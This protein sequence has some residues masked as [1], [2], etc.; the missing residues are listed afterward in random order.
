MEEERVVIDVNG[1]FGPRL[2]PDPDA[3]LDELLAQAARYR[4]G[5]TLAYHTTAVHLDPASG[6]DAAIAAADVSDGAI[7]PVAVVASYR[8][9]L[10]E[11][12]VDD[13]IRRGVVGFRL[14]VDAREWH[15]GGYEAAYR[16]SSMRA[17]LRA[18]ARAGTPII[19]PPLGWGRATAIGE[20]T[21]G[22]GVPVLI[23]GSHYAGNADDLAALDR[24]PHLYLETSRLAHFRAIE[25]AVRLV[26]AERL[27][28]G[29]DSPTRSL[30]SPIN[31]VVTA[32]IDEDEK[33]AILAGNAARL[34]GLPEPTFDLPAPVLPTDAVDVHTHYGPLPWGVPQPGDA[35]L[36]PALGRL[37]VAANVASPTRAIVSDI[38]A[39]NAQ[40]V[41]AADPSRGQYTYLAADPWDLDLTRE[42]LRRYGDATGVVGVKVHALLSRMNTSDTRMAALFDVLADYGRPVKIHNE[43]A[44][45]ADALLAIARAH[46][47]LPV[48][49][50]HSGLGFPSPDAGRIAAAAP[51]IH[52]ELASSY[53][54]RPWVRDLIARTP[55]EQLLYGTDAPL[56]N[57]AYIN[58]TLVDGGVPIDDAA[59]FRENAR[60]IFGI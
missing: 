5:T 44:D 57:P 50:A 29:S 30:L 2:N 6:N 45:W 35:D 33:R 20:A 14:G 49:I 42:Q 9:E 10:L 18:I 23:T 39:G 52:P 53:A 41:A 48:I 26:G 16:S 28:F 4:V 21:T 32:E 37:G 15:H 8:T 60:R 43:G 24:Y 59:V 58:G 56:L 17:L 25:D 36:S 47:R 11:P 3:P 19:A 13:L 40:G 54:F 51:N 7:R 55:R 46:P 38:A 12:P 34:F 22:L 1:H 27:V 31:A